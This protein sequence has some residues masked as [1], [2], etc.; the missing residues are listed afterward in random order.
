MSRDHFI[1]LLSTGKNTVIP[2]WNIH[3]NAVRFSIPAEKR[4]KKM[5]QQKAFVSDNFVTD[6]T[7]FKHPGMKP[8]MYVYETKNLSREEVIPR[9]EIISAPIME[10]GPNSFI[11]SFIRKRTLFYTGLTKTIFMAV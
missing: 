1:S 4:E 6:E 10:T 3:V 9:D 5:K 7:V 11:N 8:R 2:G